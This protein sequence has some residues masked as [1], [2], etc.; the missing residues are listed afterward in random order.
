MMGAGKAGPAAWTHPDIPG[1][2]S[3]RQQALGRLVLDSWGRMA[4]PGSRTRL[5]L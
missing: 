2:T 4:M 1:P 3:R 5:C